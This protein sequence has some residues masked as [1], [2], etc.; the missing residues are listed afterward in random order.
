VVLELNQPVQANGNGS[1]TSPGDGVDAALSRLRKTVRSGATRSL[2]WRRTQLEGIIRF[3]TECETELTAALAADLGK[4]ALASWMAD[5]VPPRNEARHALRHLGEWVGPERVAVPAAY[6]PGRAR[7]IREPKGVVLIVAPWNYPVQLCLSPLVGALAAGN[8]A[9]LKPSELAPATAG[10]LAEWLPRYV[11]PS[12]VAVVE[13]GMEVSQALLERP[14]DH[15]FFTGS[16]RVGRIVVAAAARHLTPVTLELGGKSPV[17][18]A[19]DADLDVAARRIA[20]AKLVNAGQTC[21]APDYVLVERG[22]RPAFVDRLITEV[23]RFAGGAEPTRIVNETH[24]R[25]LAGLLDGHGGVTALAGGPDFATARFAP[26][27]ITDPDPGSPLMQEEIFG[28]ILPVVVTDSL[29]DS[30]AFVAARPKPLALYLFTGS[31]AVEDEVLERTSSGS[32]CVNH[33]LY[34]CLVPGLP[35]GGVGP[36]GMGAY[37]GRAGFETFS[38]SKAV[39]RKPT[40]PDPKLAYPPYGPFAERAFRLLLR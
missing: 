38:H 19:A 37:H 28:P 39:L 15:I 22:I 7:I 6:Q 35:F 24:L 25:R 34:Q 2:A 23:E 18:V 5:I 32:V 17:I 13:G 16:P 36:S 30:I 11:D 26:V 12:A 1:A 40:S 33:L 14:F 10:V 31:P 27:V 29:D 8:A 9:V 3:L 4:P 20:W 21:I